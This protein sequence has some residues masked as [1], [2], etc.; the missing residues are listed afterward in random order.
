MKISGLRF[1]LITLLILSIPVYGNWKLL[2]SG[3]QTIGTVTE[4]KKENTGTLLS[5]FSIIEYRVDQKIYS[6]KGPENIEYPI[7]KTFSILYS[8]ENPQNA[9]VFSLRGIYFNRFTSISIVIFIFWMA[10][11]LSFSPKSKKRKSS[12]GNFKPNGEFP[13]KKLI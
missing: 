3:S 6:L 11:Y 10:F 9:L 1:T 5:Y 4:I 2:L 7:G 12:N 8:P 13:R